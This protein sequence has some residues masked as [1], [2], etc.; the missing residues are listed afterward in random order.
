MKTCIVAALALVAAGAFADTPNAAYEI[1]P[2]GKIPLAKENPKPEGVEPMTD[3][4]MRIANV[5][6]PQVVVTPV[7]G[8]EKPT[9]AVVI[10]PGGGYGILA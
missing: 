8:A 6:V 5:S 4:V 2:K 3:D 10:C 9:P 1:W 7:V